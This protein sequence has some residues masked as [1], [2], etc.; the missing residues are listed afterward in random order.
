MIKTNNNNNNT[1]RR[2][3]VY[4]LLIGI[5]ISPTLYYAMAQPQ[6]QTQQQSTPFSNTKS[7]ITNE[8]AENKTIVLNHVTRI[9]HNNIIQQVERNITVSPAGQI[10]SSVISNKPLPST[11]TGPGT[12]STPSSQA[13]LQSQQPQPQQQTS[14]GRINNTASNVTNT[15]QKLAS[16]AIIPN[17]INNKKI[18]TNSSITP[19]AR[20][21]SIAATSM[22]PSIPLTNQS[23]LSAKVYDQLKYCNPDQREPSNASAIANWYKVYL[24]DFRCGHVLK[25]YP[26]GTALRTFT[27]FVN[28]NH[29]NGTMIPISKDPA[30]MIT[31]PSWT[32]NNTIPGPT[33]RMTQGDHIR[34][35][36]V[37]MNTSAFPHSFHMHSVHPGDM[38][39][40][41]GAAGTILPG[42]SFTYIFTASPYGVYPYHCHMS[43]TLDHIG[44]GLIGVMLIDPPSQMRRPQA[45]EMVMM[46]N[47]YSLNRA[48]N[49]SLSNVVSDPSSIAIK[50][51]TLQSLTD[52]F[53]QA[54]A[55]DEISSG[56]NQFYTVNGMPFAYTANQTVALNLHQPYR[57]YL[58]NMLEIDPVNSFHLHGNMFWY[59]PSGTSLTPEELHDVVTLQQG[60]RGI[61]EFKYDY[62]GIYMF[63]SHINKFS[64]LG[65]IGFFSVGEPTATVSMN[66]NNM[67]MTVKK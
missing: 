50:P 49:G 3:G 40:M 11:A 13:M 42:H 59:Y 46:L 23:L 19:A 67:T 16:T 45:A 53:S 57:I 17:N 51:P 26:N 52:N 27:L 5:A 36:V 4:L 60:D 25:T 6:P 9:V 18:F 2:I 22:P 31:F 34:V 14:V 12:V 21:S 43:P 30:N 48:Y 44:R 33:L 24:T 35:T 58:V 41:T 39:G 37:N 63:H 20:L 29:G 61:L 32:F 55:S 66:S 64:D 10:I 65:W 7:N 15:T 47:G 38:D 62:P 1:I 54:T 56:D 28:D 8:L